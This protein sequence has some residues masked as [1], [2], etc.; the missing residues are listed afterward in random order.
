MRI[1]DWSSDV[2]SADLPNV[3]LSRY[4]RF[5]LLPAEVYRGADAD[6]G[7]ADAGRQQRYAAI[8]TEELRQ[9]I[10][11]GYQLVNSPGPDVALLKPTLIGVTS[12]VRGLATARRL[13]PVGMIANLATGA[14]GGTGLFPGSRPAA[15][16]GFRPP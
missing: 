15:N 6:F 7:S 8:L 9:V 11:E 12:T 5:M 3:D 14:A 13:M 2:C 4:R 16:A 10:G 1:S